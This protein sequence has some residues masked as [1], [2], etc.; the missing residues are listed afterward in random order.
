M[1]KVFFI[2][3]ILSILLS[4]FAFSEV[5]ENC[6][7]FVTETKCFERAEKIESLNNRYVTFKF[8]NDE[9]NL[10]YRIK[11]LETERE[12]ILANFYYVP[13]FDNS[14]DF[15]IWV[16]RRYGGFYLDKD[17]QKVAFPNLQPHICGGSVFYK[18]AS[19]VMTE[20]NYILIDAK[21]NIILNDIDETPMK[22]SEGL[23]AVTLSNGKSGCIN[24]K[25]EMVFEIPY[26]YRP[27]RNLIDYYFS[28]GLLTLS[29]CDFENHKSAVM[30]LN[31][32]IIGE[33][34]YFL[35][36]FHDGLATFITKRANRITY[37]GYMDKNCNIIIP[38]VL[39]KEEGH[40]LPQF[41]NGFTKVEYC[42]KTFKMD[43][44]GKL[45]SLENGKLVYDLN[46]KQN[47]EENENTENL[48]QKKSE[49]KQ[50]IFYKFKSIFQK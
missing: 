12:T 43:K 31:G 39:K 14:D 47:E 8:V 42:E 4:N 41:A 25:G 6:D 35:G 36:N 40:A 3:T 9:G 7:F 48:I 11:D 19:V 33:T 37:F 2:F 46:K 23:L 17:L 34:S 1:K 27:R 49:E 5:V 38:A 18:N 45:Y 21:G 13:P 26:E 10:E 28:D 20:T 22:F 16:Y 29:N 15:A 50:S 30:D 32:N 24:T 44:I